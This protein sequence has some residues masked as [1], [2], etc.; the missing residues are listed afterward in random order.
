MRPETYW[1]KLLLKR[2]CTAA[3]CACCTACFLRANADPPFPYVAAA[4]PSFL[5]LLFSISQH[6]FTFPSR[7]RCVNLFEGVAV[8]K[9]FLVGQ[10][11]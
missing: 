8:L 4:A 2:R 10:L 7:F 5:F 3:D 6:V 1:A 11:H 9:D